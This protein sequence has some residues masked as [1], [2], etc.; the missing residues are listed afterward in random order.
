MSFVFDF[1]ATMKICQVD[2]H[3][4][5]VDLVLAFNDDFFE[6]FMGWWEPIMIT[7]I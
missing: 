7:Y 3:T 5:Y 2:T 6:D 4:L 1:V